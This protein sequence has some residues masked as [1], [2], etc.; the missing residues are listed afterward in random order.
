MNGLPEVVNKS[1]CSGMETQLAELLLDEEQASQQVRD[2]VAECAA[3]SEALEELRATMGLLDEWAAPEPNPFF[4]TRMDARLREAR[5]AEP[6]FRLM[7]WWQSLQDRMVMSSG[8]GV[9][10]LAAMAMSLLLLVGGGT[11][12][13]LTGIE[14]EKPVSPQA[15]VVHELQTMESNA[16]LLDQLDAMDSNDD[17]QSVN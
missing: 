3:C 1:I 9:R 12:L 7:R 14:P 17:G 6:R 11:W 15:S 5:E 2:H 4:L 16:Q 13:G 10:P 8:T